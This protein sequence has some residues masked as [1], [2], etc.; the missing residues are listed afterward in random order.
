MEI[1]RSWTFDDRDVAEGFDT[2]VREQLPWYGLVT[3]ATALVVEHYLPERGLIYDFGAST[4]NIARAVEE[5]VRLRDA[6]LIPVER[7]AEMAARYRGPG[8]DEL[9]VGDAAGIDL[10][11]FDVAICFLVLMFMP[12]PVREPFLD[13]LCGLVRP[14]GAVV[15]VDKLELEHGYEGTVL[16]RMGLAQKL[17]AGVPPDQILRKELSLAGI[18]RPLGPEEIPCRA[19]QWFRMG[20]FA[21]WI[22]P[23]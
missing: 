7:S 13:R 6:R 1:P 9:I 17:E 20:D 15:I 12:V 18:Q 8:R 11:P 14:G 3:R 10:E 21:G 4:G 2:H 16:Q 22:I 19:R 23:G 5:I